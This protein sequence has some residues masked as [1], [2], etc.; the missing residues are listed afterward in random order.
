MIGAAGRATAFAT[1]ALQLLGLAG[2]SGRLPEALLRGLPGERL[3]HEHSMVAL[4][5]APVRVAPGA[6]VSLGFF[7]L[8]VDD[9]PAA[10]DAGRSRAAG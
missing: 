7:G 1:D 9:H 8:F 3:Q 5:H 4:Q 6:R 2:R 10:T